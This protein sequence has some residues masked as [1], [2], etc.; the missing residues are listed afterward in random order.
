[1]KSHKAILF[2][3]LIQIATVALY[4]GIKVLEAASIENVAQQMRDNGKKCD[5]ASYDEMLNVRW[6][7]LNKNRAVKIV[8]LV[9]AIDYPID[10]QNI[11]EFLRSRDG[12]VYKKYAD[13]IQKDK[14]GGTSA[15]WWRKG[16][17]TVEDFIDKDYLRND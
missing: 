1:M 2:V 8:D 14:D 12:E 10:G 7:F 13:R 17:S 3:L 4:G 16:D 11:I 6:E 5:H 9:R 15:I